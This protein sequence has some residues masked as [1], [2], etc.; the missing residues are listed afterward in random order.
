MDFSRYFFCH[1]VLLMGFSP[2]FSSTFFSAL[3]L[4]LSALSSC[5]HLWTGFMTCQSP[6]Y[7][8]C[9]LLSPRVQVASLVYKYRHV[10]QTCIYSCNPFLCVPVSIIY[11][12]LLIREQTIHYVSKSKAFG[13][14]WIYKRYKLYSMSFINEEDD[15]LVC[16]FRLGSHPFRLCVWFPMF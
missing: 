10:V 12:H 2:S 5:F 15:K 14:N 16:K 6:R 4:S 1:H 8:A 13:F 11:M 7:S 3:S 9:S